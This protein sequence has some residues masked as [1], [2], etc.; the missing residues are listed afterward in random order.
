MSNDKRIVCLAVDDEPPALQVIEK[1]I[2]AIPSLQLVASCSNAV[3]AL[4]VLQNTHVDLMFLDIQMP[5]IFGTDFMRTLSNPPKVIFT[6]AFRKYAVDGF[7]LDAVDYLLKPIS[8]ERFLKAVNKVMRLN[9]S[10]VEDSSKISLAGKENLEDS[11]IYLRADRK[12]IKLLLNDILFVESLKDY[13]KV[14]TKDKTIIAKQSISSFEESLPAD[15]FIRVHRS[16]IIA[17]NKI[18][19][20]NQELVQISKYEIPISRSYRH[21]FEKAL[22]K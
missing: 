8:F 2:T 14:I 19:S 6:T 15:K 10:T 11:F 4:T 22:K 13:I 9:I 12:N 1:Y 18:D 16:F 7:E 17:V 20:F 5:H 3:E 21:E